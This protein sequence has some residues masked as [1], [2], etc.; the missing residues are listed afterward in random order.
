MKCSMTR[1]LLL[2]ACL[3]GVSGAAVA[4]LFRWVDDNG[5]VHYSDSVPPHMS[6]GGHTEL[7]A[8]GNRIKKVA[9]AKSEEEV[10]EE[11]WLSELEEKLE[12]KQEQQRRK[13]MVLLTSYQNVE[14]FDAYYAEHTTKLSDERKQLEA[15]KSKL[16][17]E[18]SVLQRQLKE[19]DSVA[20]K[21]RTQ[22]FINTNLE[23]TEAYNLALI[24]NADETAK[25][26]N[27]S[28]SLRKRFIY[29]LN[30]L[31]QDKKRVNPD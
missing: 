23:N 20:A 5:K 10:E 15:L 25:L 3:L 2:S 13:D 24:Q 27:E 22:G 29:L 16:Q 6:Q 11:K 31:E 8:N 21:E 19:A 18:L 17:V 1:N 28:Q 30:K 12:S 4:G 26:L 14:E 7:D 9:A